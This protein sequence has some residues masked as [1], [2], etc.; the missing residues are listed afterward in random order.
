MIKLYLKY[1]DFL[2]STF[3]NLLE[4][5][6]TIKAML[7]KPKPRPPKTVTPTMKVVIE[8][9]KKNTD[10]IED[11]RK[12]VDHY[13]RMYDNGFNPLT[14]TTMDGRTVSGTYR[15]TVS[16]ASISAEDYLKMMYKKPGNVKRRANRILNETDKGD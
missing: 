6:K 13:N 11:I 16:S 8:K 15:P 3:K 9:A 12:E 7:P 5:L 14:A 10:Y 2:D 1:V 4:E